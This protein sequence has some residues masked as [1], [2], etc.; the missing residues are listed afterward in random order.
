MLRLPNLLKVSGSFWKAKAMLVRG[1]IAAILTVWIGF[2]FNSFKIKSHEVRSV[3]V[4]GW[5]V[6]IE[7]SEVGYGLF[8]RV[9][10]DDKPSLPWL[11][12]EKEEV[13]NE[14]EGWRLGWEKMMD[15][16]ETIS[17][18]PRVDFIQWNSQI[19]S[20]EHFAT[21]RTFCTDCNLDLLTLQ[22]EVLLKS[23]LDLLTGIWIV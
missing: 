14:K 10:I 7:G 12:E 6:G 1:P 17:P 21:Q 18:L 2:S 8:G 11:W 19:T 23:L 3:E 16:E 20:S 4:R 22:T 15:N 5:E 13:D 9:E